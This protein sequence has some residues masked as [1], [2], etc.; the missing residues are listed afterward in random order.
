MFG[1]VAI[2]LCA[3]VAMLSCSGPQTGRYVMRVDRTFNRSAQPALPSDELAATSYLPT[4]PVD[5]WH[6]TIRGA[7]VELTAIGESY[8]SAMPARLAGT[9]TTGAANERRFALDEGA[10]AGGHF[11]IR[12]DEAELTIYGSGVPVVS[13][14]RGTLVAR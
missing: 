2:W 3:A 6:V 14:E 7:R 9:E 10:F 5:H 11:V 8:G 4:T 12:G 13:S 1:R